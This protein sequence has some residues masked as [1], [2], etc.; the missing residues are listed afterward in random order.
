MSIKEKDYSTSIPILFILIY[1]VFIVIFTEESTFFNI[2]FYLILS[3]TLIVLCIQN[4]SKY[5]N[6]LT[7]FCVCGL[8]FVLFPISHEA[9]FKYTSN[10]Y[11]SSEDYLTHTKKEITLK[12]EEY[13]D[14]DT[15]IKIA[16]RLPPK[17]QNLKIIDS[18]IGKRYYYK[19]GSLI[20]EP[21]LAGMHPQDRE[22]DY[23]YYDIAF[24]NKNSINIAKVRT[25]SESI[26]EAIHKKYNKR[27]ELKKILKNPELNIQYVDI[28]LDSVTLFVFSNIKPIGRITQIIQLFQVITSFIFVYMLTTLLDNFK[29]LKITKKDE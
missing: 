18:I 10:N 20:V 22:R 14:V 19:N 1:R 13:K 23:L 9:L 2:T 17:I 8:T 27:I 12:L 25:E 4:I 24:Y 26:I 3:F 15:L 6:I 28:W 7:F 16:N 29:Q 5:N 21:G 11:T